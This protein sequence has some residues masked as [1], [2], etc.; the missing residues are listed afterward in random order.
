MTMRSQIR[1]DF[2]GPYQDFTAQKPISTFSLMYACTL[3][4]VVSKRNVGQL[5]VD[6]KM[7]GGDNGIDTSGGQAKPV[8]NP[9]FF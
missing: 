8:N 4:S 7:I 1:D 2:R 5:W 3:C 9:S 6:I